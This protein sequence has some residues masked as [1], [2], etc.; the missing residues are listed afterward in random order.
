MSTSR[1]NLGGEVARLNFAAPV[2][3]R[4]LPL[5]ARHNA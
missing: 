5:N 1:L 3:G 2:E 4:V